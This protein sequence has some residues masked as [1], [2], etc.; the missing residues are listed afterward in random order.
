MKHLNLPVW[1][2]NIIIPREKL[3]QMSVF[4]ILYN[5][6]LQ[7]L[8]RVYPDSLFTF[9]PFT[10]SFLPSLTRSSV[11]LEYTHIHMHAYA[12]RVFSEPFESK[13]P[14]KYFSVYF[15]SVRGH[16]NQEMRIQSPIHGPYSDFII[17]FSIFVAVIPPVWDPIQIIH[18]M[19][20]SYLFSLL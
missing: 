17:S 19:K 9:C 6:S 13:L 8:Y 10:L 14:L 12:Y 3:L 18:Y 4:N 1:Q 15:Q 5:F 11:S 7:G 16:Q 20:F 2:V